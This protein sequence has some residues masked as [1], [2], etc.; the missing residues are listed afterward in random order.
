MKTISI[1]TSK[2]FLDRYYELNPM[3]R[4]NSSAVVKLW[5]KLHE[6]DRERIYKSITKGGKL[7]A[8]DFLLSKL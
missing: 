3:Y 6:G 2:A 7:N 4:V 5:R 1:Y 8:F